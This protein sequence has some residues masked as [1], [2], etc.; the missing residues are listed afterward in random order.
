MLVAGFGL[1]RLKGWA[2]K[3]ALWVAALQLARVVVLSALMGLV[4]IPHLTRTVRQ[5]A[6]SDF[7]EAF[8]RAAVEQSIVGGGAASGSQINPEE[9]TRMLRAIGNGATLLSLGFRA[10]YPVIVLVVLTRAGA[11]AACSGGASNFASSGAPQVSPGDAQL[12]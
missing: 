10:I 4:V 9:F 11:R 8:I 2:R 1:V 6:R 7:G 12:V 3:L 5:F